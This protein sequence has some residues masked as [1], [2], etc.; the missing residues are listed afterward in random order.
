MEPETD[1]SLTSIYAE[2]KNSGAIP[3]LPHMFDGVAFNY[4]Q[5]LL[6]LYTVIKS[7][8]NKLGEMCAA[9]GS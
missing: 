8:R 5:E 7:R 6:Y 4:V 3:S 2:V 9:Y 1:H